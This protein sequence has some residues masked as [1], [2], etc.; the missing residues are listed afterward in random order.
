MGFFD[1]PHPKLSNFRLLKLNKN[2]TVFSNLGDEL[3]ASYLK[4]N[5]T[6]SGEVES[7]VKNKPQSEQ[8]KETVKLLDPLCHYN[9]SLSSK[10]CWDAMRCGQLCL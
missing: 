9:T 7:G 1:G 6:I 4:Q 3:T 10:L 8:S 5:E 2:S